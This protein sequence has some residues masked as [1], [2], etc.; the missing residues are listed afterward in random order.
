MH[1]DSPF[2]FFRA[3]HRNL[4]VQW[5]VSCT[6]SLFEAEQCSLCEAAQKAEV[7]KFLCIHNFAAESGWNVTMSISGNFHIHH[8]ALFTGSFRRQLGVSLSFLKEELGRAICPE[9][10]A[11]YQYIWALLF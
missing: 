7:L 4:K 8:F 1:S 3:L 2:H 6:V 9:H 5:A 11:R 10:I